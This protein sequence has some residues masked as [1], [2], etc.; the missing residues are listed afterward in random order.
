MTHVVPSPALHLAQFPVSVP[1][2][3]LWR[4]FWCVNSPWKQAEMGPAGPTGWWPPTSHRTLYSEGSALFPKVCPIMARR[5][6][7]L[8]SGFFPYEAA[9]HL[10]YLFIL[11]VALKWNIFWTELLSFLNDTGWKHPQADD[12][13]WVNFSCHWSDS[14]KKPQEW[15]TPLWD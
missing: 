9:S 13:V 15:P 10:P 7:C 8:L 12:Q 6:I 11:F 3:L 14:S 1:V 2:T 5:M 4:H